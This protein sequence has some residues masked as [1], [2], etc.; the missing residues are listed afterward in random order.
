MLGVLYYYDDA[1]RRAFDC[2]LLGFFTIKQTLF[3]YKLPV[4]E[5]ARRGPTHNTTERGITI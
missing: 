3:S 5:D 1:R 2:F 4:L